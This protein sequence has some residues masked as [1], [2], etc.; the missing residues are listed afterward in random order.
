MYIYLLFLNIKYFGITS[1][2]NVN[3]NITKVIYRDIITIQLSAQH[4]NIE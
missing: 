4:I 1:V 3:I 2:Y